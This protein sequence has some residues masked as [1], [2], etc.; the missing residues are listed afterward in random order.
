MTTPCRSS[1]PSEVMS[2]VER[3]GVAVLVGCDPDAD[4]AVAAARSIFAE[5]V[6][7]I[8]EPAEVRAGGVKDRTAA[9]IDETTPLPPHTDGFAYGDLYPDYFLLSCAQASGVGGESYAVDGHRVLEE[10]RSRPG[11]EEL[12]HRMSLV[13]I[14]QTEPD[15]HGALSPLVMD[16]G[17][18]RLMLRRFP[19]QRPAADSDDAVAD[20]EMIE[21]WHAAVTA[22]G[23]VAPRFKVDTGEVVVFDNYRMMHGRDPYRDVDRLMWRV[24]VWTTS[25][26]GLPEGRLHSDS[27]YASIGES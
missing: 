21:R 26:L 10:L 2:A 9:M 18:G 5:R 3:D 14:D 7:A 13:P 20:S 11:G 6:V 24:W 17:G 8:P 1:D 25:A 27:R 15:M 19:F 22:A 23:E 12:L 16:N 4:A